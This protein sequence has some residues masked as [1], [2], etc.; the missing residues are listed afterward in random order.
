[1][2]PAERAN[3]KMLD[4]GRVAPASPGSGTTVTDVNSYLVN[5]FFE[6]TKMMKSLGGQMGGPGMRGC[7][8]SP[9]AGGEAA[10]PKDRA[11][12]LKV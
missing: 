12:W 4:E 3:P 7:R 10:K 1:M 2:T 8:W 11:S 9:S 6:A 5:R